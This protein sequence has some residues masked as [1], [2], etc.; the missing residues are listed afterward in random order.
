MD[1]V[2]EAALKFLSLRPRSEAEVRR[3][4]CR[5]FPLAEVEV[6]VA[7]LIERGLLDDVAFS[8]FWRESRERHRPRGISAVRWELL[9]MGV[10]REAA[11]E[12]LE[13]LDEEAGA[14]RAA[15]GII[16]RL[17][18]A[19]Y[20]SF[21]KI[22]VGHLQRRGFGSEV[23]RKTIARLWRELPDSGDGGVEGEPDAEQA[24]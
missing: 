6:A 8:R 20:N 7:A 24:E 10:S 12:A 23:V 2:L 18:R 9:R 19:D 15:T 17:D 5:R 1:D 21:R 14:Y 13:G 16:R 11:Q 3:R 22:L 4:L